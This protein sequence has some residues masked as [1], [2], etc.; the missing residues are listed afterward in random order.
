MAQCNP[1]FA[2]LCHAA[3]GE[4]ALPAL[5]PLP[6]SAFTS[7]LPLNLPY[8]S[9]EGNHSSRVKFTIFSQGSSPRLSASGCT[10]CFFEIRSLHFVKICTLTPFTI[11]SRFAH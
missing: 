4:A 3:C 6:I 7:R 5:S 2:P 1:A 8:G 9:R 11:L 10:T